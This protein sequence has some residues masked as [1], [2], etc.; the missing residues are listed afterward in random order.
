MLPTKVSLIAT[1]FA[2]AKPGGQPVRLVPFAPG[3]AQAWHSYLTTALVEVAKRSPTLP[4]ITLSLETED[5][6]MWVLATAHTRATRL[7]PVA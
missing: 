7:E 4:A 3:A 2:Q 1:I 6:E 5:D